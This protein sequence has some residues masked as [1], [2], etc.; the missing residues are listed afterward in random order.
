MAGGILIFGEALGRRQYPWWI[1]P[2]RQRSQ[3]NKSTPASASPFRKLLLA[4]ALDTSRK[5]FPFWKKTLSSSHFELVQYVPMIRKHLGAGRRH[6][7]GSSASEFAGDKTKNGII[8]SYK[9]EWLGKPRIS[10]VIPVLNEAETIQSVVAFARRSPLVGEVIVVDD[11]S[12]DG[13]PDLAAR[14]GAKVVTSTLLGKGASMADGLREAKN[15]FILYLDGDLKGLRPDVIERMSQPLL[16]DKADFVKACFTRAAGRVTVLTARP[17]LRTYFPELAHFEQP[18]SGVMAARKSLLQKLRFENDYGVDVGLFIDA[19]R[20]KARL[21]EVDIGHLEHESHSLEELG[22]MATQVA[23]TIL[24]RAGVSGRLRRS[25]MTEVKE[26]ER[27]KRAHF[28][29]IFKRIPSAGRI[30]LFDM[31][32]VL[33]NGRFIRAL[34]E[35]AGKTAELGKFLDNIAMSAEQRAKKIAAIFAGVPK[36]VFEETAMEI[37]L[38]PGAIETVVSLRKIGYR[39]GIVTDSYYVA[40]EIVR[41]RVFADFSFAHLMQ[42]KRGKATGRVTLS[43]AMAHKEGCCEHLFCKVNVLRHLSE[44]LSITP[45]NIIA[46]GDGENDVCLLRAVGKSFAFEPKVPQLREAAQHVIDGT[47]SAMLSLIQLPVT[48]GRWLGEQLIEPL[49]APSEPDNFQTTESA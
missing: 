5:N 7:N 26:V 46:V 6:A 11:G 10:V 49:T 34:A 35:R 27:Q 44:H 45:E 36:A 47:L 15:E 23:R 28:L 41:R 43:P 25:F 3:K 31:D 33:L 2:S 19:A 40:S 12:I 1:L 37:P 30:A 14:C 22:E 17:L 20:E 13:T 18:L 29:D 42:F 32:G 4:T 39:V 21:A 9:L 24:D 8:Q 38:T 48:G 16:D